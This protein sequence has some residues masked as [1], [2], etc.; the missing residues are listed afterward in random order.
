MIEEL[1]KSAGINRTP[2]KPFPMT[3]DIDAQAAFQRVGQM[4][5]LATY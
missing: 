2:S 1:V 4:T 5:I 3:N